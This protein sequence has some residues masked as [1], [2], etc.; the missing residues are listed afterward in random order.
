MSRIR[1]LLYL[2]RCFGGEVILGQVH[3]F[4][5]ETKNAVSWL[6]A[7]LQQMT[8]AL[9]QS[10][11]KII[12]SKRKRKLGG[13]PEIRFGGCRS[14]QVI[15]DALAEVL[16]QLGKLAVNMLLQLLSRLAESLLEL[17]TAGDIFRVFE[18]RQIIRT[19]GAGK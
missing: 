6:G 9:H 10:R 13:L 12:R 5:P 7:L 18:Q 2:L 11:P 17:D 15:T 3:Q 8:R 19:L 1:R 4:R 14:H 16:G